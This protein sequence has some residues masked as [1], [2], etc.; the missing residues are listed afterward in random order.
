MNK[1]K[2]NQ[3]MMIAVFLLIAILACIL[4]VKNWKKA[5]PISVEQIFTTEGD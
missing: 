1:R 2:A 4:Q 3:V 5:E